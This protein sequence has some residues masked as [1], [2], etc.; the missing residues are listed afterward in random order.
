MNEFFSN[1]WVVSIL[2]GITVYIV[3]KIWESIREK[4]HYVNTLKLANQEVFNTIKITIPEDHLPSIH[5]LRSL[6]SATA[7]RY[8][9]KQDDMDNLISILDDLSKEILDSSF[10]SYDDKLKYCDKIIGVQSD[11]R[12]NDHIRERAYL[13]NSISSKPS[14]I[15]FIVPLIA[16]VTTLVL[17]TI[18]VTEDTKQTFASWF[19]NYYQVISFTSVLLISIIALAGIGTMFKEEIVDKAHKFIIGRFKKSK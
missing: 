11:L 7:K 15:T 10:L 6:H 17:S 19:A 5:I 18:D 3:T 16:A 8:G 12:R 9:V 13:I 4:R 2:T 1:N 14:V